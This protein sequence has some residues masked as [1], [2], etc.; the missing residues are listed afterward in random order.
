MEKNEI[1]TCVGFGAVALGAGALCHHVAPGFGA[2]LMPMV[3]PVAVLATRVSI[4]KAAVTAALVPL[5]SFL[6]TGMPAVPVFVAVKFSV[7]TAA[8]ALSWRF[9]AALRKR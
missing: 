1:V 9:V 5:A 7:L 2:V 4:G 3:W 6:L 8:V